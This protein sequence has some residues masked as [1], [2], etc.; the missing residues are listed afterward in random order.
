MTKKPGE[1]R[2]ENQDNTIHCV[3]PSIVAV[4]YEKYAHFLENSDLSDEQKKEFL[5]TIWSIIIE[6]V[7][8]GFNVHPLQQIEGGCGQNSDNPNRSTV[9][10]QDML[11]SINQQISDD[12]ND[13]VEHENKQH[14][15][16]VS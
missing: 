6:F 4:D 2:Q 3:S 9:L 7:S 13:Q 8:L 11:D 15:K 10:T 14:G 1:T 5:D 12:F 16:G